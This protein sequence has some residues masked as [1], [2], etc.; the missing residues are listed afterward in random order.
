MDVILT[1]DI[2]G[3]G[4]RGEKVSVS[5]GYYRNFLLPKGTGVLPNDPRANAILKELHVKAQAHE[6]E[7]SA[8]KA[9][10]ASLD[11][12]SITLKAKAKNGKLFGGIR[13]LEVA[14]ALQ[15]DKKKIEMS[16][17]KSLGTHQVSLRF[18]HGIMAQITVVVE[19]S[20]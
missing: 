1:T 5:D 9:M 16:P 11:G 8:I 17:I 20:E 7:I 19:A 6:S 12:R 18:A 14:E 15:I 4:K 10:A 2:K 13:E 3:V